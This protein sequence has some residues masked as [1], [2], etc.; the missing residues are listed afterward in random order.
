M[1]LSIYRKIFAY[2]VT[3]YY[4]ENQIIEKITTDCITSD[5][6][7]LELLENYL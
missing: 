7:E 5:N 6:E 4:C 3:F 1:A 2:A